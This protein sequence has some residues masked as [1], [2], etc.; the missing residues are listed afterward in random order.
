MTWDRG[1]G[2]KLERSE[3]RRLSVN[4]VRSRREMVGSPRRFGCQRMIERGEEEEFAC[5]VAKGTEGI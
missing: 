2:G 5:K 1:G 4:R 3:G